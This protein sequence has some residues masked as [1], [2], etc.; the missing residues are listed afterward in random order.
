MGDAGLTFFVVNLELSKDLSHTG[1]KSALL[2]KLLPE[3]LEV[4]LME[5]VLVFD[6]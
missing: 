6:C 5:V 4:F 2:I 1:D 3:H